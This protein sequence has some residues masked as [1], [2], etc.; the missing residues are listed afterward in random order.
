M[1]GIEIQ[2]ELLCKI[3]VTSSVTIFVGIEKV[4]CVFA[5]F[6]DFFFVFSSIK[7]YQVIYNFQ[8]IYMRIIKR[9]YVPTSAFAFVIL[10]QKWFLYKI[11]FPTY[12]KYILFSLFKTVCDHL[13]PHTSTEP[14]DDLFRFHK[15][16]SN[17]RGQCWDS[18][19][20]AGPGGRRQV[21]G[22]PPQVRPHLPRVLW[23]PGPCVLPQGEGVNAFP[24]LAPGIRNICLRYIGWFFR[25]WSLSW[26]TNPVRL[27]IFHIYL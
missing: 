9:I 1:T 20:G 15:S 24:V 6:K 23:P 2:K 8:Q 14:Q 22:V 11:P 19:P 5:F 10:R 21:R 25:C 18:G 4:N 27:T 3:I 7:W 26:F 17:V 12:A 16:L 13:T